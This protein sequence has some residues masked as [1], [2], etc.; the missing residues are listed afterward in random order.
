MRGPQPEY[1]IRLTGSE[2]RQLRRDC[3]KRTNEHRFVL[4]R[5]VVL[6]AADGHGNTEIARRLGVTCDMVQ[7]WRHRFA[8]YREEGLDEKP[9]SGR[10][11][12]LTSQERHEIVAM[13]YRDPA[14]FGLERT[15]WS[16]SSITQTALTT[17]RVER[18]SETSV[19]TILRDADIRPH[20]FRMWLFSKDPLFDEK[21]QDIVRLYTVC[22][23]RGEVVLSIDEKTSIQALERAA[24]TLRPRIGQSG[25]SSSS[26]SGTGRPVSLRVSTW[27]Q[28]AYSGGVIRLGRSLTFSPTSIASQMR[29]RAARSTW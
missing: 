27:A 17:G 29:T 10:P 25:S 21:M 14:D 4:R 6:L 23:Q 12:R 22:S 5:Q 15:H 11:P 18:I 28:G 26:T 1:R 2:R 13:A 7:R 24:A 20:H 3:R 19:G 8:V 16:I 9:R